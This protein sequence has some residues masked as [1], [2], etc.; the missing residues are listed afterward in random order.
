M[1]FSLYSQEKKAY[2]GVDYTPTVATQLSPSV[3]QTNP[4]R[5]SS[6]F[7]LHFNHE[8][9][10]KSIYLE[11]GI[12]SIDR[13][14]G[15]TVNVYNQTGDLFGRYRRIE[16]FHCL[17]IPFKVGFKSKDL[18]IEIGPS[19]NYIY[20]RRLKHN[21]NIIDKTISE[22]TNRILLGGV[23]SFGT[24]FVPK[25]NRGLMFSLGAYSNV[26]YKPIYLNAGIKFG[27][28]FRLK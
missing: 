10:R 8:I 25:Y 26:T 6:S 21:K 14:F 15:Y 13:G 12:C 5:F 17:S 7:G 23:L 2:F 9:L 16:K 3:G 18:Y 1:C 11:Y 19:F 20:T 28:K 22:E 27:I 24:N 4:L